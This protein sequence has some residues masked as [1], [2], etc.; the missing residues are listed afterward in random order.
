MIS[1]NPPR[2]Y[3]CDAKPLQEIGIQFV[4]PWFGS[5]VTLITPK[6]IL[7]GSNSCKSP[8]GKR[9]SF[10]LELG[11][12]VDEMKSEEAMGIEMDSWVLS[13]CMSSSG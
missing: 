12:E 1:C 3:Y 10:S 6:P 4:C 5:L 2:C 9:V 11:E 8:S 13:D 7:T